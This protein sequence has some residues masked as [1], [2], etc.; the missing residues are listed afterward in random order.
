MIHFDRFLTLALLCSIE[1]NSFLLL[2]KL[3]SA[4]SSQKFRQQYDVSKLCLSQED[5]HNGYDMPKL[6]PVHG[7]STRSSKSKVSSKG[8]VYSTDELQKILDLH[9]TLSLNNAFSPSTFNEN[10]VSLDKEPVI[11]L[12]AMVLQALE[13]STT[14]DLPQ[15]RPQ[16]DDIVS[17]VVS[18]YKIDDSLKDRILNI[19]AIA[20]DVDGTLLSSNHDLHP[21]TLAAI[22]KAV[23]AANSPTHSLQYF[24]LATGK[25]RPGAMASL[26]KEAASLLDNMPG[27][28]IQGLYCVNASGHV[29]FEQKIEQED[30][31]A[32]A[33]DLAHDEGFTLL[34]YDGNT[35]Y[36]TAPSFQRNPHHVEAVH[37]VWGEPKPL[38]L[39]SIRGYEHGF[40]KLI[41]MADTAEQIQKLRPKLEYLAQCYGATVTCAVPTMLELLPPGSGKAVGVAKLC[42]HIGIDFRT[43]VLAL[44]DGEN[45]LEF[46]QQASIGVAMGNAVE[47]VKR[48]DGIDFIMEET[49]NEGGAGMAIELFG[50]L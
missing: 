1:S 9:Q 24:I 50:L 23:A 36:S 8:D 11:D 5:D 48:A 2:A 4:Q 20:S 29:V 44:G 31:L 39:Q 35:L 42:E 15:R 32:S 13:D 17:Q 14:A 7:D 43:Q 3:T 38:I 41:I 12:H 6:I 33:E 40:H 22:Q 27:V 21:R 26:G 25:S 16:D 37:S 18:R 34:A 49:N 10:G 19:R 45:D 28:F 30:L 47:I 46:L